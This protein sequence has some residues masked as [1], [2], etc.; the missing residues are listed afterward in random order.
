MTHDD[1]RLLLS[2]VADGEAERTAALDEHLASCA[3]C[4]TYA[5]DL[6]GLSALA[7][8]LPRPAA[9][10]S[11]APRVLARVRGARRRRW[12]LRLA[13][14]LAVATAVAVVATT[15]TG[16]PGLPLPPAA[17]A[18]PLLRLRSLYVERTIDA[19]GAVTE[20]KVW[21]RAPASVRVERTTVY[22]DGTTDSTLLV[23]TPEFRYEYGELT[24]HLA[25]A[26]LQPEPVSPTVALLGRDTGPGPDVAGVPT[27]AY[28]LV[29]DGERRLAYVFDGL[30]LGGV[31]ALVLTKS[32]ESGTPTKTTRV[33]RVN[34]DLPDVLFAPPEAGPGEDGGFRPRDLGDLRIAPA[35]RPEGF[36]VVRSGAGR[37]GEAYLLAS[38]SLPVLVRAGGLRRTDGREQRTVTHAGAAYPV[39]VDLYAP[40]SVQVATPAGPVTV[41]AP[42]PLESL[43][44]LAVGMYAAEYRAPSGVSGRTRPRRLP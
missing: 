5:T 41:S 22:G 36:R 19:P 3:G 31:D 20:E 12:A 25:P 44:A 35:R 40:P 9:P 37:E 30:T 27:R 4:A 2:A 7:A 32:G 38:G 42:L 29:V 10:P 26:I 23:Q 6:A 17:A 18:E 15:L 16:A 39:A 28:E 11:L 8:A 21:W 13:P 1:A 33:L 34:P 24:E 43:A 14:A